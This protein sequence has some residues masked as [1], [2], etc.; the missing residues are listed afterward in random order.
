MKRAIRVWHACSND[1]SFRTRRA[2]EHR[3]DIRWGAVMSRHRCADSSHFNRNEQAGGLR[4]APRDAIV[5]R[6]FWETATS[7]NLC[8]SGLA[9]ESNSRQPSG[10]GI[11]VF[12][13]VILEVALGL[14]FVYAWFS[15]ACSAIV[16]LLESIRA[17]RGKQLSIAIEG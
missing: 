1:R 12:G 16:E 13:S 11:T 14:V 9:S 4:A 8:R 3:S 15:F 17:Q 10:T 5:S 7:R 6:V 2:R